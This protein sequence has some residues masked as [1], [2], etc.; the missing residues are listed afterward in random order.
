MRQK[1]IWTGFFTIIWKKRAMASTAPNIWYIIQFG[2][3]ALC[4]KITQCVAW[5]MCKREYAA[6]INFFFFLMGK[7]NALKE[8][9]DIFK[10]MHRHRCIVKKLEKNKIKPELK[11]LNI[12]ICFKRVSK[13]WEQNRN[14]LKF[15]RNMQPELMVLYLLKD[16]V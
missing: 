3:A 10:I 1:L 15:V 2:M 12:F 4:T 8:S 14:C 9:N 13:S 11:H 7:L 5:G 16:C 6:K